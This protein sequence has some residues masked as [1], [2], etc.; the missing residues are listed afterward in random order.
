M[1]VIEAK[2]AQTYSTATAQTLAEAATSLLIR[3]QKLM[4]RACGTKATVLFATVDGERWR[5]GKMT[6]SGSKIAVAM[7][8]ELRYSISNLT[9]GSDIRE[10]WHTLCQVIMEAC[11]LT[12]PTSRPASAGSVESSGDLAVGIMSGVRDLTF[13]GRPVTG[14]E[15]DGFWTG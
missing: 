6:E 4:E 12:P 3:K 10:I 11:T 9:D 14:G 1:V 13:R 7:A 5:F 2:K 8:K 15:D